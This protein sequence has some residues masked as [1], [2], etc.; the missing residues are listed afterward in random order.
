MNKDDLPILN[1]ITES[2]LTC[3]R[4]NIRKLAR[5][6]ALENMVRQ[7]VPADKQKMW[8]DDLNKEAKICLQQLLVSF[9]KRDPGAAA[10]LD[11]RPPSEIDGI[12]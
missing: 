5:L 1:A 2:L 6:K 11:D 3:R 9:E 4:E 12:V 8:H 7:F 10:R